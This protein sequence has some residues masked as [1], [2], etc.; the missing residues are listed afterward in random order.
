MPPDGTKVFPGKACPGKGRSGH[1][2]SVRK[3]PKGE[4]GMIPVSRAARHPSTSVGILLRLT[5]I[6]S[7]ILIVTGLYLPALSI[8][9]FYFFNREYSLIGGIMTMYD[10]GQVW[11]A[12]FIFT[13]TVIFPL[14]KI[15]LGLLALSTIKTA[16]LMTRKILAALSGASK[17][18]MLDVFALALIVVIINGKILSSSQLE[19]G[20]GLFAAGVLLSTAA[21][22]NLR[23]LLSAP[24]MSPLAATG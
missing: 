7:L 4:I 11:L 22:Y 2:F 8:S 14:L 21:I 18:S 3:D 12:G 23:R 24:M 16:P 19:L 5:L 15:V 17:W 1:R 9:S 20:I 6:V 10:E 13:F